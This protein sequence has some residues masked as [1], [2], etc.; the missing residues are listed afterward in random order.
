M[1]QQGAA[2]TVVLWCFATQGRRAAK[3]GREAQEEAGEAGAGC[4]LGRGSGRRG[5]CCQAEAGQV[6]EED[7]A[8][9][10][11]PG[12]R[13]GLTNAAALHIHDAKVSN[14]SH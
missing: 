3:G 2:N 12:I 1:P 10:V 8:V 13:G 4:A 5:G 11:E 6:G 7:G 14:C 9:D